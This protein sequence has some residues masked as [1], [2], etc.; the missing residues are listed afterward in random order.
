MAPPPQSSASP[1]SFPIARP[2]HPRHL[3]RTTPF[4]CQSN[5]DLSFLDLPRHSEF[6]SFVIIG[7]IF[8]L[9]LKEFRSLGFRALHSFVLLRHTSGHQPPPTWTVTDAK[10]TLYTFTTSTTYTAHHEHLLLTTSSSA[11]QV[12]NR[13]LLAQSTR[14]LGAALPVSVIA[15]QCQVS[16]SRPAPRPSANPRPV[17]IIRLR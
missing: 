6:Y 2:P 5:Q 4:P 14:E 9:C 1:H 15:I 16:P 7:V 17:Y 12:A 13:G 10:T 8:F 3:S 11:L